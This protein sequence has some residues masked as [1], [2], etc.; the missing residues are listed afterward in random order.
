MSGCLGWV[1][2]IGFF[3]SFN[4]WTAALMLPYSCRE[5]RLDHDSDI[6]LPPR[7]RMYI[8]LPFSVHGSVLTL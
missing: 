8:F 7:I 6:Q 3:K 2:G 5:V 1:S 4:S